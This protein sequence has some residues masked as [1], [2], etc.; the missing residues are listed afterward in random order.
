M[1]MKAS[2]KT[3]R[4]RAAKASIRPV[5]GELASDKVAGTSAEHAKLIVGVGASAGGLEA[6][7]KFFGNMRADSGLAF[8][9]VQHLSPDYRS[10]MVE[11][12]SKRT[13]ISVHLAE[14]GQIVK[15]N[16]IYLIPPKK[17][18][19]IFEGKLSLSEP[20]TERGINLPI[21]VFFRSLAED[22]SRRA[23]GVVLSGTGSDGTMG[24][25]A[26]KDAGGLVIVQ[27][28]ATAQFDGMPRSAIG[29]GLADF[30]LAPEEMSKALLQYV[31]HPF[32]AQEQVLS[33]DQSTTEML[34]HKI[35]AVLR[36]RCGVDF[37]LYKPA[38]IDRRIERRM[39]VN[40]IHTLGEYC[41]YLENSPREAALL[42]NELLICVTRFLRDR[43]A[44]DFLGKS[45]LPDLLKRAA[46]EH[47]VRVWVP[48]CSTGE[49]AY[50]LAMLLA[51]QMERL[52]KRWDL[53]IFATDLSKDAIETASQGIYTESMVADV[54]PEYLKKYF[55]K[56]ADGYQVVNGLRKA[57][58]FAR[59][60]LLK[61]PPFTKLD[62]ISCRNLLIYFQPTLQAKVL[63]LFHF[64]LKPEGM[65][66]LGSSESLGDAADR[67]QS[68]ST[69]YKIY[70]TRPVTRMSLPKFSFRPS[71][72]EG[73]TSHQISLRPPAR[74]V[75]ATVES[76]YK[77]IIT[78]CVAACLVVDENNDILHVLGRAGEYLKPPQG[79]FTNNILKLTSHNLSAALATALHRSAREGAPFVYDNVTFKDGKAL[80]KVRLRIRQL[81]GGTKGPH[82]RLVFIEEKAVQKESATR[83]EHYDLDKTARR[84]IRDLEHE[85][86]YTKESLQATIEE[87]ET[88]NEELQATNEELL[89]ANEEL[90][91]T[92][93]ELQSVNEELHTVNAENLSRIEELTQ[94][95][96]DINNLLAT[97]NVGT[98]LVDHSL[99]IRR[100]SSA[101]FSLTGLSA[102]DV[103]APL[104]VVGRLLR[105]PDLI[106]RA[107]RVLQSGQAE[108]G[109][110]PH[111]GK[112]CLLLRL[113]PYKTETNATL[114]L[115]VTVID[116]T[117][118]KQSEVKLAE[119]QALTHNI[120]NSLPL[121]VAVIDAGGRIMHVNHSWEGF[122]R[123]S[124]Q[125]CH[126]DLGIGTNYFTAC[127]NGTCPFVHGTPECQVGTLE[128][129]QGKRLVYER[130]YLCDTPDGPQWYLFHVTPLPGAAEGVVI[131][132]FNITALRSKEASSDRQAAA[133]PLS[134]A[135]ADA[136]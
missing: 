83:I 67:F 123:R 53:K 43:D 16:H 132:H 59:H 87:L 78:D 72:R 95:T 39:S 41:R 51:E 105:C 100:A 107:E 125:S 35:F 128:V 4:A 49:E 12:L 130:E 133:T 134:P 85:L 68:M 18:L 117:A 8:V 47:N 101:I 106:T 24:I 127:R 119:S 66:F 56:K 27:S 77:E 91:S 129:L 7:G 63:S 86:T 126:T 99:R 15:P 94:L 109:E 33:R 80:R 26:I 84:R 9:V 113:T 11:L 28:E 89:A 98:M 73:L 14:E 32:V 55:A 40:Q 131:C 124:C 118:R 22:Q 5:I 31:R 92:N 115:V 121:H 64:A 79:A 90:Q 23:V 70:Q 103:G 112:R 114:G 46:A 29:T 93:E 54:P 69:R 62:L 120:L 96:N 48:G 75:A 74:N 34:M 61:D 2:K 44:F 10:F 97:S 60:D 116:I 52:G 102:Q 42:F 3:P 17:H 110:L 45:I 111:T 135:K 50:S 58:I 82:L 30:I 65:L 57:V 108:E 37:S 6:L 20:H 25:R 21:D 88:A 104:E 81:N 71:V 13:N 1:K 19:K 122:A 38:T 76:I 136:R 36:E